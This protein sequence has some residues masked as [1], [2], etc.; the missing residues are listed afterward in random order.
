MNPIIVTCAVITRNDEVLITKRSGIMSMPGLWEFPGGK[1]EEGETPQQSI[2]REI[3][4]EL[5][6]MVKCGKF[7]AEAGFRHKE[8]EYIL[9]AYQCT[10]ISGEIKLKEHSEYKWC[11]PGE[12]S[13][14]QFPQADIDIIEKLWKK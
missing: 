2:E 6:L 4:E 8:K 5:N 7:L 13:N 14:Y 1:T 12:L 10:L 3:L 11:H 9:Q